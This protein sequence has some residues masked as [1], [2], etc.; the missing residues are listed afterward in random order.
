MGHALYG[1]IRAQEELLSYRRGRDVYRARDWKATGG[2]LTVTN[3]TIL[4]LWARIGPSM[5]RP[6]PF[7]Q[8]PGLIGS[9]CLFAIVGARVAVGG[10]MVLGQGARLL[11]KLFH[12]I[13]NEKLEGV[14]DGEI[15]VNE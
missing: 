3:L 15:S 1:S 6:S 8:P 2:G 7:F 14:G 9:S 5:F 13:A 10:W 11:V 12:L 4:G